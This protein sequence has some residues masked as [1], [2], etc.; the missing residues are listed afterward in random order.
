ME[1][2]KYK[3]F[4]IPLFLSR[5]FPVFS[6]LLKNSPKQGQNL[7][8]YSQPW[9]LIKNLYRLNASYIGLTRC[10][11]IRLLYT[12]QQAGM[13]GNTSTVHC[14]VGWNVWKYEYCIQT[15]MFQTTLCRRLMDYNNKIVNK[16]KY[17]QLNIRKS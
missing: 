17:M 11:E 8:P 14:T 4:C 12:V 15:G 16:F 9:P 2:I 5:V 3:T 7:D 6:F 10:L 1:K 13:F